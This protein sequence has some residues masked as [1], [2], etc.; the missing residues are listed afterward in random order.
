METISPQTPCVHKRLIVPS[1]KGS[2]GITAVSPSSVAGKSP[3]AAHMPTGNCTVIVKTTES[4][5]AVLVAVRVNSTASLTTEGVPD[6]IP[7]TVSNTNPSGSSGSTLNTYSAPE[8]TGSIGSIS[9]F[10]V[11]EN[12]V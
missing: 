7:V 5:P 12:S 9:S 3:S 1:Y 6:T 11:K 10:K 2:Q 4:N 8:I